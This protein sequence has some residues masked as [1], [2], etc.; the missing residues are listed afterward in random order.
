MYKHTTNICESQK[1]HGAI[2]YRNGLILYRRIKT[3]NES[4]PGMPSE[5]YFSRYPDGVK[6]KRLLKQTLKYFG[7]ANPV[8]KEISDMVSEEPQIS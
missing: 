1:R 5:A 2:L 8:M 4:H 6:P 3:V 7:L